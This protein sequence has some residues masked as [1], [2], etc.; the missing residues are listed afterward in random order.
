MKY[1]WTALNKEYGE[2][3]EHSRGYSTPEKALGAGLRFVKNSWFS[4]KYPGDIEVEVWTQ[5]NVHSKGISSE[6]SPVLSKHLA[7]DAIPYLQLADIGFKLGLDD[8]EIDELCEEY[9]KDVRMEF[10]RA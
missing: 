9:G 8:K 1:Y 3:A 7:W 5:P 6:E 10:Q 2:I 4:T